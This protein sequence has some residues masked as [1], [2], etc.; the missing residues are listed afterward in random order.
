M[1]EQVKFENLS[2]PLKIAAVSA[3]V[4]LGQLIVTLIIMALLFVFTGEGM[5]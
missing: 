1:A 3:W 4:M 5:Y 2:W